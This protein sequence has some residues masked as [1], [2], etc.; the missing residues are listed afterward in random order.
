MLARAKL[1]FFVVKYANLATFLAVSSSWLLKPGSPENTIIFFVCPPKFYISIVFVFS[2]D[3]CKSQENLRSL[4]IMKCRERVLCFG[5]FFSSL[6]S[7]KPGFHIVVSVVSVVR[8]KFIRQIEF[9]L[10]RT[11][12]CICRFFCIEHLY[13]RFP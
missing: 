10:S 8:K 11:T 1:P 6:V 7:L 12:S 2:W 4:L 5:L 13:G 3:H 9:I